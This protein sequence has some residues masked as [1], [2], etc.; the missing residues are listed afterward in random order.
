VLVPPSTNPD[1]DYDRARDDEFRRPMG[2]PP[3]ASGMGSM[4]M[5][6]GGGGAAEPHG[7]TTKDME[8]PAEKGKKIITTENRREMA[9]LR[10]VPIRNVLRCISTHVVFSLVRLSELWLFS[11]PFILLLLFSWSGHWSS[12]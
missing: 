1:R 10:I 4:G 5:G 7:V 8:I 3:G 11:I 2:A 12:R 6:M 9:A